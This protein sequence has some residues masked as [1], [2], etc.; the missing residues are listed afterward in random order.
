MI[1]ADK[2]IDERKKAGWS[3]E[4]LAAKLGVSRQAVS[5]W[6]GA[7]ATPDLQRIVQMAG[8]FGVTTDYLLKE[9]Y[10][11]AAKCDDAPF[12]GESVLRMVSLQEAQDFLELKDWQA[13]RI[14]LGVALCIM[15]PV[16]MLVL[17]GMLNAGAIGL[18]D[19]AVVAA[20]MIVL[21]LMVAAAVF[22]FVTSGM[23]GRRFEHFECEPFETA[24]GVTGMVNERKLAFEGTYSMSLAL[25]I[26]LCIVSVVPMFFAV[27]L[28][29][30]DS[31]VCFTVA[32]LL[33]LVAVGVYMIV[34]SGIINGSFQMLLQEGDYTKTNKRADSKLA[35]LAGGYWCLVVAIYLWWSF[36]TM[37][38]ERTWII[39]PVAAVLFAALYGFAKA[40]VNS[41]NDS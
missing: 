6:E 1:L 5:K 27:M 36:S 10:E 32:V 11:A 38:W 37:A 21:L 23:R 22:L 41:R 9:D 4:E 40:F 17:S 30:P 33:V 12:V 2:I 3:Q 29:L 19:D 16:A 7:Q 15:S 18:A 34:R 20:G 13:P 25:G 31:F 26:V 39:W 35:P 14:A 28:G 24:Y 8:L